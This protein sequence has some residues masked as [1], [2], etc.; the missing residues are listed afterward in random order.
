MIDPQYLLDKLTLIT[1]VWQTTDLYYSFNYDNIPS[2]GQN[3]IVEARNK[4]TSDKLLQQSILRNVTIIANNRSNDRDYNEEG[5]T[6]N[7]SN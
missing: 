7:I 2:D 6:S 4:V 5:R 1:L 3:L